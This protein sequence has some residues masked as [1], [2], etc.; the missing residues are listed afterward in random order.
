MSEKSSPKQLFRAADRAR[1]P[2]ESGQHPLNPNSEVHG[3]RL[4]DAVGLQRLGVAQLRIP[5]GKESFILHTHACEEEW[6]YVLSG[7]GKVQI[8]SEVYEVGPGD[9]VGFSTPSVAHHVTNPFGEDLV[10]LAG[11]ER[12]AVEIADFPTVGKRMIRQNWEATLYPIAS[13]EKLP[14]PK[15]ELPEVK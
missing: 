2:E 3:H 7:R 14:T 10:Y 5:P 12:K 1:L 8:D 13:G 4:G 15:P 6:M 11:G 9:F